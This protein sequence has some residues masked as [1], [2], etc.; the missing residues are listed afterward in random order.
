MT[1]NGSMTSDEFWAILL[2]APAP[3]PI[4]FRLYHDDN[5]LPLF[6]SMEDLPGTY[7]EI[8]QETFAKSP[9]NVRVRNGKLIE[10]KVTVSS[11]LTPGDT[12]TM[13]HPKDICIVVD[14]EP[15]VYWSKK[16][17]VTETN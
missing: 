6:Y 1:N 13:C 9:S 15:A 16:N 5:G 17:Y 4:F 2:D 10:T 12:G 7:I 14:S 11:K 3:A 8:D